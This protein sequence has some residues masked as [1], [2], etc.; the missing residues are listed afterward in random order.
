[1]VHDSCSPAKLVSP[2]MSGSGGSG[3]LSVGAAAAVKDPYAVLGLTPEATYSE[4]KA[5][6]HAAALKLHPDKSEAEVRK[7]L[8]ATWIS[9]DGIPSVFSAQ[10]GD[11]TFTNPSC[12]SCFCRANSTL[13]SS[14]P[15]SSCV[16]RKAERPTKLL[17]GSCPASQSLWSWTAK[18]TWRCGRRALE[19]PALRTAAGV[20]VL[21]CCPWSCWKVAKRRRQSLSA[22]TAAPCMPRSSS[23]A[24]AQARARRPAREQG[25]RRRLRLRP[26]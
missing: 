9:T 20:V 4:I 22:V 5:A 26:N 10:D 6:F 21:S 2:A 25:D 17:Q 23:P 3:S 18:R 11:F 19:L 1:M 24:A 13:P 12:S 8:A 16:R 15:G 7:L 14:K